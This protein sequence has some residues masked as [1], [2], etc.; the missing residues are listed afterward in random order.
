MAHR[1]MGAGKCR[2]R[3]RQE[4]KTSRLPLNQVLG[5]HRLVLFKPACGQAQLSP[6]A[7]AEGSLGL[8]T[9]KGLASKLP[10][11]SWALKLPPL[12]SRDKGG[13][14][15]G[16]CLHMPATMR[17]HR[18]RADYTGSPERHARAGAR[19]RLGLQSLQAPS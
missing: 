14:E 8:R 1:V 11:Q 19:R 2:D 10:N 9:P 3:E 18:L 6:R 7:T 13:S 5:C 4:A 12:L 16:V 17:A 15:C